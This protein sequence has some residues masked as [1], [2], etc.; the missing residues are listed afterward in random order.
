[1]FKIT[2][3]QE[4]ERTLGVARRLDDQA[5]AAPVITRVWDYIAPGI[6]SFFEKIGINFALSLFRGPHCLA[7]KNSIKLAPCVRS[8]N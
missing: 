1:M 8:N 6:I 5:I 2:D 4:I 3:T 7:P